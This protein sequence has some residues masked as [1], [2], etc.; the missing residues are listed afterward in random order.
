MPG[1]TGFEWWKRLRD[2][3]KMPVLR[4]EW[5]AETGIKPFLLLAVPLDK[6]ESSPKLPQ[7]GSSHSPF[8]LCRGSNPSDQVAQLNCKTSLGIIGQDDCRESPDWMCWLTVV[9]WTKPDSSRSKS[10]RYTNCQ[11]APRE[12]CFFITHH[13]MITDH[14]TPMLKNDAV[15]LFIDVSVY[16]PIYSFMHLLIYLCIRLSI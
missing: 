10:S 11:P 16:L 1:W 6:F 8:Q 5:I 2:E 4:W 3:G 13:M 7:S 9:E 14:F 12:R 15:Y